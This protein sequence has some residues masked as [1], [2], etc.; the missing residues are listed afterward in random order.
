M[1]FVKKFSF[2]P[3][4]TELVVKTASKLGVSLGQSP[5]QIIDSVDLLKEIDLQRTLVMLKKSEEKSRQDTDNQNS[6]VIHK[7]IVLS[8]DLQVEEQ[9]ETEGHKDQVLPVAMHKKKKVTK[10]REGSVVRRSARIK[11]F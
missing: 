2:H 10:K 6:L 4:P 11:K 1:N 3:L 9:Q 8:E 5:S 7:A